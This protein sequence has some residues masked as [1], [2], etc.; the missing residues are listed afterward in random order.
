MALGLSDYQWNY[1]G[2]NWGVSTP[3][4]IIRIDGLDDL[5]V[6]V[7]DRDFP[8]QHGQIPGQHLAGHR[9]I[10]FDME[11]GGGLGQSSAVTAEQFQDLIATLSP[12]SSV[13]AEDDFDKLVW[14]EPGFDE[15]FIRCRPIRRRAH[16]SH[17]TEWGHRPISFQL[18][19]A[20]PR[21]YKNDASSVSNRSRTFTVT[22][23]GTARAYPKITYRTRSGGD[24][25]HVINNTTNKRIDFDN[26]V[27]NTNYLFDMDSYIRG[28]NK[29]VVVFLGNRV[30]I[31]ERHPYGR[32][33]LPR[34]PLYLAP[35]DN[36]ITI[37]S[38]DT[39]S[40]EWHDTYL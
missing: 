13:L 26:L 2:I 10:T 4:S 1:R 18:R 3:Y 31:S 20:D 17:D 12:D 35:G 9:I 40:M 32:W 33:V 21:K 23:G 11:V 28:A 15:L 14:K 22:N 16:R 34:I 39:C 24:R 30:P 27:L 36:T 8:R 37:S 6:R 19:A 5:N 38:G 25:G 29:P 7:G